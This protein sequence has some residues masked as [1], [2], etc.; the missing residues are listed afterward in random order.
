[1]GQ[2]VALSRG[3]GRGLT[4]KVTFKQIPEEGQGG[5]LVDIWGKSIF[6]SGNSQCKGP[7]AGQPGSFMEQ[8]EG[9][10]ALSRISGGERWSGGR[11]QGDQEGPRVP[12]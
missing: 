7:E 11:Q 12:L 3:M 5:S 4:E 2:R 6:C 9:Q 8:Q 10:C 1:M